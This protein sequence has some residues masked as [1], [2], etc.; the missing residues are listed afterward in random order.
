MSKSSLYKSHLEG[1]DS[2]SISRLHPICASAQIL[3]GGDGVDFDVN[4]MGQTCRAFAIRYQGQV[5]AY[6]NRCKHVAIEMDY[7]PNRFFDASGRW[8]ICSTHGAIYEPQTGACSGGPCKSSLISITVTES[9]GQLYWHT[10]HNL[11]PVDN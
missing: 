11:K 5:F 1:A 10:A 9:E 3:D 6:L 8:L 7:V 4:Y 2:D